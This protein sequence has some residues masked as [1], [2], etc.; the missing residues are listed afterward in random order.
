VTLK[1]D[2]W[3]GGLDGVVAGLGRVEVRACQGVSGEV[4]AVMAV[5]SSSRLWMLSFR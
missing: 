5:V 3:L 4:W 2:L 1:V